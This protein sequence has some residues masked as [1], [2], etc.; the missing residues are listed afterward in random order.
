MRTSRAMIRTALA[1]SALTLTLAACAAPDRSAELEAAA[2]AAGLACPMKVE[3]F[4]LAAVDGQTRLCTWRDG[5]R[6]TL[7]LRL[8]TR[9]EGAKVETAWPA[10][11]DDIATNS[12]L[13]APVIA[14]AKKAMGA[15]GDAAAATTDAAGRVATAT[16]EGAGVQ[17]ADPAVIAKQ[18]AEAAITREA[19][20]ALNE[21]GLGDLKAAAEAAGVTVDVDTALAG[22][23]AGAAQ[24]GKELEGLTGFAPTGRELVVRPPA[25]VPGVPALVAAQLGDAAGQTAVVTLTASQEAPGDIPAVAA[26]LKGQAAG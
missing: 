18:A 19:Q 4:T 10:A 5:A 9:A 21:A 25:L 15:V 12:P 20:T 23:K 22:L 8:V 26:V 7:K 2:R 16:V 13:L 3:A 6:A 17:V 1:A 11:L 14:E 24:A